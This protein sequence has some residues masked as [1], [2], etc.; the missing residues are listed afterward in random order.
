[1]PSKKDSGTSVR[2][3]RASDYDD[4]VRVWELSGLPHHPKG[5]DSRENIE[6]E[7]RSRS[8]D[9][10]VAEIDGE[11][12]GAILCTNDGRKGWINRLAVL[13]SS[14]REGIASLLVAE[15][16]KRFESRGI[17]IVACLIHNDN[18]ASRELFEK[19]GYEL[20]RRVVYY[21][22]RKNRDV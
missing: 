3:M 6:R 17:P 2:K 21:S 19:L 14:Q 12:V 9:F 1:M 18:A 13:P 10:L 5:R 11:M 22:K 8:N 16:E 15:A 4:L 20:D 7:I